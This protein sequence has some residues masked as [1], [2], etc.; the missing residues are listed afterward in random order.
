MSKTLND[1]RD[2]IRNYNP[3]GKTRRKRERF[4]R[5]L[6]VLALEIEM[7]NREK[8]RDIKRKIIIGD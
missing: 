1:Y 3:V 8:L 7:D 6:R 5:L 4:D 2:V